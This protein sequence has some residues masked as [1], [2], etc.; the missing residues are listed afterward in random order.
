MTPGQ[1]AVVDISQAPSLRGVETVEIIRATD[2]TVVVRC[3]DGRQFGMKIEIAGRVL[4]PVGSP[5][6]K[7]SGPKD[8]QSIASS[9]VRKF[10]GITD[11]T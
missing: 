4:G 6:V 11:A 7:S 9:L 10:A 2:T 3:P 1:Y 8:R 5:A